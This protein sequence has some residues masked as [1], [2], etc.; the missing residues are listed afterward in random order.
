MTQEEK[1]ELFL[2]YLKRLVRDN[3]TV[4]Y[5]R[6]NNDY[7]E[8]LELEEDNSVYAQVLIHPGET[9]ISFPHG[10]S[11]GFKPT[12][13][14]MIEFRYLANKLFEISERDAIS[15]LEVMNNKGIIKNG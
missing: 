13:A 11:F 9:S 1:E 7:I 4:K 15:C 2:D 8:L 14:Q 3:Q 5:S 6:W 10:A 12:E